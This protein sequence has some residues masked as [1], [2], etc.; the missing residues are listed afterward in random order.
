M[1]IHRLVAFVVLV[2]FFQIQGVR[3][4][5]APPAWAHELSDI[6]VSP[7]ITF[8]RL[9]NGLRYALVPNHTPPGQVSMRLLVLA[10]SLNEGDDELGYAHFVEH[11]AFR[12]TRN[13]PADEK[14]K[15]LQR[16]G[17]GF[18]PHVNAETDSQHTLYKLDLPENSSTTLAG[19]LRILRDWTDGLSFEPEEM[20]HE[21]GV[22]LSEAAGTAKPTGQFETMYAGTLIVRRPPIGT[23]A[24]VKKAKPAGLKGFYDA[25]YRP[26][27]MVV[28]VVGDFDPATLVPSLKATFD[29][30]QARGKQRAQPVIGSLTNA[31]KPLEQFFSETRNGVQ[32]ELGTIRMEPLPPDTA[33]NRF[34]ALQLEAAH[35]MLRRRLQRLVDQP[36]ASIVGFTIDAA[37]PYGAFRWTAIGTAGN[38]YKWPTV[39]AKGEQELRRALEHGF[40]ITELRDVQ[41]SFRGQAKQAAAAAATTPTAAL[42][43]ELTGQIEYGRVFT[44]PEERLTQAL[45]AID[46]L[47]VEG[48]RLALQQTWGKSPRYVFITASKHLID[49]K[50]EWIRDK[51]RESQAVPVAPVVALENPKFAYED[52]GPAG[53]VVER[54]HIADLDLWQVR[55]ANGV[56]LNLK[57]NDLEH[58]RVRIGV[59]VGSGR[60]GEP[61][62]RPGLAMMGGPA[63]FFGG[64]KKHSDDELQRALNGTHISA[65]FSSEPDAFAF[66][67][68]S[69]SGEL[70]IALNLLTAFLTD[71]AFRRSAASRLEG[72]IN[73]MY[74]NLDMSPE[75]VIAQKIGSFLNGEDMRLGLPP[76]QTVEKYSIEAM[77]AW[78]RP[79]FKNDPME[80]TLVGDFEIDSIIHEIARTFG[81]LPTRK[82]WVDQSELVKLHF[83]LPPSAKTFSYR[84]SGKNRPTTLVFYWPVNVP[85]ASS[86]NARLQLLGQILQER[87]RVQIRL[88]KGEAYSPTA[89]F[90][91]N[92]VYPGLADINCRVD[93]KS[94]HAKKVGGLVR[95]LALSLGTQGATAD[96]LARVKAVSIADVRRF[97]QSND[98]WSSTLSDAQ[99]HPWRLENARTIE[100]NY[101][102]ATLEEING[103]AAKFLA[104]KNLFQF[105]L[106]P[107]YRKP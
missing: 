82:A 63:A 49:A 96:E 107:D 54:K 29:S 28:V 56:R 62:D 7:R 14:V 46:Q 40:D 97:P 31:A 102:S 24:S 21:R 11:M 6:P 18:G 87:L 78:L 57:R 101:T 3:A 67:A 39:L 71:A 69:P 106:K 9:D 25:W 73:D 95:T 99:Q 4:E 86:D 84:T 90:E 10:G 100:G 80:V 20:N 76:R 48:C 85:I 98:Y 79:I 13:F 22:V 75:G 45:T 68:S 32:S 93:V 81:A 70:P 47:T 89:N 51:I 17:V 8:G 30:L 59:R 42:A 91:W 35:W 65:S 58:D 41:A 23:D 92:D 15:F 83:P 2:L 52:F 103:F 61:K 27:N 77:G 1:R 36:D 34:N 64:L 53:E 88:E 50:P 105:T 66:S 55:F 72:N 43:D 33:Q 74:T 16:I 37:Y 12:S 19:A 5:T 94:G 60:L 38:V 104:E 26:E 44:F